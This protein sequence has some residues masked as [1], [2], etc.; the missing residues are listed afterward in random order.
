MR[1]EACTCVVGAMRV[2]GGGLCKLAP[3]ARRCTALQQSNFGSS[4][5]HD[6]AAP[7]GGA[8]EVQF[9]DVCMRRLCVCVCVC[10]CACVRMPVCKLVNML[11]GIR[12]VR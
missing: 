7:R 10:L 11:T 12:P 3:F 2:R 9:H 6:E 4:L 8:Q 1:V 5:M